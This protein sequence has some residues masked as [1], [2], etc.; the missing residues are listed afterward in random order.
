MSSLKDRGQPMIASMGAGTDSASVDAAD[1][2]KNMV[3][4]MI[5]VALVLASVMGTI[6]LSGVVHTASGVLCASLDLP[7]LVRLS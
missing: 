1:S 4:G 6:L 7:S 5:A 3:M 2:M